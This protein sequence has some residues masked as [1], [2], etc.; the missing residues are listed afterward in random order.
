LA[1][2]NERYP[3]GFRALQRRMGHRVRPAWIWERK[4]LGTLELIIAV[5][6]DGVAGIPGVLRL[7][8]ESAD[9]KFRQSG[10]L[11]G[12]HSHGGKTRQA[13]FL[14]PRDIS[15]AEI[16]LRAEMETR[17]GVRRPIQWVRTTFEQRWF[18]SA[19]A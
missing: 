2:Y 6:N 7:V 13:S 3:E 4:R 19:D 9:G 14:L 5:A 16:K 11:D 10:S 12:G 1:K 15:G 18:H 8:I 17:G